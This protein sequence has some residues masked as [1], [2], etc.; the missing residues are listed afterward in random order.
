MAW[1]NAVKIT[2]TAE[3][4]HRII[5]FSDRYDHSAVR[6]VINGVNVTDVYDP[7][8][9]PEEDHRQVYLYGP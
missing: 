4:S 3:S 2:L 1:D 8:R 6:V 5:H 9:F 7:M